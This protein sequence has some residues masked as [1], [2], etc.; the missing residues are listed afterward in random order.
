[1]ANFSESYYENNTGTSFPTH[2][3]LDKNYEDDI[4][5]FF[6]GHLVE[7]CELLPGDAQ[8]N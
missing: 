2:G 5:H 3:T 7:S 4:F 1:L 6:A 8:L